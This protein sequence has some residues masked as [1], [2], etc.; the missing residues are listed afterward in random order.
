MSLN[1]GEVVNRPRPSGRIWTL[2][3]LVAALA[4]CGESSS[5]PIPGPQPSIHPAAT[6]PA[7]GKL[8]RIDLDGLRRLVAEAK[9]A[10]QLLVLDFWATWCVPCVEMFGPL[11]DQL[12]AMGNGVRLVSVTLDDPDTEAA[13]LK[14]LHEH[15]A[16][17]DAYMLVPDTDARLRAVAGIAREWND[18]VVP[19]I[20]I[21][22]QGGNLA[23]EFVADPRV[24]AVVSRARELLSSQSSVKQP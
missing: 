5:P 1:A 21:Y 9:A 13:A 16:R 20:L 6:R 12:G 17:T 2:T 4:G 14:F 19:A 15:H 3:I 23:S 18:L 7:S 22:D 11:H 10:N 24:G 8:D